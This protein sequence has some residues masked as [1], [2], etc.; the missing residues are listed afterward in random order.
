[1]SPDD[2]M[3]KVLDGIVELFRCPVLE[4]EVQLVVAT[5]PNGD[6]ACQAREYH[7]RV[8][9]PETVGDYQGYIVP[10]E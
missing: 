3:S 8:V 4:A 2:C 6:D 7:V 9:V 5:V 1:M 10:V